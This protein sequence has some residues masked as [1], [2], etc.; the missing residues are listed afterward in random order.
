M[1]LPFN[2]MSSLVMAFFPRSK[3]GGQWDLIIE[4]PQDWGQRL[5]EGTNKILCAP[6]D[7]RNSRSLWWRHGSTLAWPAAGSGALV[8][9]VRAQ[10][11][12]K[13]VAFTVI[14]PIIV[15]P[16]VKQ[17]GGNTVLPINRRLDKVLLSQALPIRTRASFPQSL[18]TGSFHKPL[19]LIHQRADRMKTTITE[20]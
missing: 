10:V 17:Q 12:L 19:I 1:S 2:M 3:T 18:P 14:T 13:E 4:L 8:T 9:T 5:L 16:Q 20:T 7:R 15:C 6:G 11:L